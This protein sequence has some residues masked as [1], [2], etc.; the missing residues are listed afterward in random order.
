MDTTS[1][2]SVAGIFGA[3][4]VGVCP[5]DKRCCTPR[6]LPVEAIPEFQATVA[7]YQVL[8]GEQL[9]GPA[10]EDPDTEEDDGPVVTALH[11]IEAY[12]HP[13]AQTQRYPNIAHNNA[14]H[15][16]NRDF[17]RLFKRGNAKP[18]IVRWVKRRFKCEQC[19]ADNTPYTR[20][21]AADPKATEST[22]LS[23]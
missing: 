4:P 9:D 17:V 12:W 15:P 11:D 8:S 10:N 1:G 23:D 2:N 20:R 14:G 6:E 18:A 3:P 19:M 21:L 5:S 22:M 13:G 16:M 7:H